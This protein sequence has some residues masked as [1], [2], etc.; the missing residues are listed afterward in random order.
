[1]S[2]SEDVKTLFRRF[3]GEPETYQEVVRERQ[4]VQA[5]GKWAMLGQ[6]DLQHV[7]AVPGVHRAVRTS[8][9]RSAAAGMAQEDQ[10][11][12]VRTPSA[13][14]V[15]PVEPTPPS[16]A[17][18]SPPETLP[19]AKEFL[20]A[21]LRSGVEA[22]STDT[23]MVPGLKPATVVGSMSPNETPVSPEATLLKPAGRLSA[24]KT[25]P[26][27]A[28]V[29]P[30]E[31]RHVRVSPLAARLKGLSAPEPASQPEQVES[32][33]LSGL[34]GRLSKPPTSGP[35]PGVLRRKFNR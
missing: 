28:Q 3:G 13:S 33:S 23:V 32:H 4:V 14:F 18:A 29:E 8:S 30:A 34:F 16:P 1:M 35:T 10:R 26:V 6:V 12:P 11:A 19:K 2:A 7:P 27:V 15:P 25:D 9:V 5:L 17:V 24:L 21:P 22:D 20:H 31:T